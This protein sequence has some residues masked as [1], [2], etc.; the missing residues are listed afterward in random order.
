MENTP[1][2]ETLLNKLK[3]DIESA[4]L[5]VSLTVNQQLLVLYWKIGNN[6]LEQ[7]A[8]EGWGAKII[9]RLSVDLLKSFPDMK[10]ISTRNLKYMRRFAEAYPEF[11]QEG[12]AQ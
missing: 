10:G 5:K 3:S 4:R 8:M 7:Q 6:I 2:Y 9:D 12:L 11:V 1:G